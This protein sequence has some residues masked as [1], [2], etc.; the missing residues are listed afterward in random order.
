MEK[1]PVTF[2]HFSRRKFIFREIKIILKFCFFFSPVTDIQGV[3]TLFRHLVSS[4]YNPEQ[5]VSSLE[6]DV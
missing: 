5:K 2:T 6:N 1:N 4:L 3:P